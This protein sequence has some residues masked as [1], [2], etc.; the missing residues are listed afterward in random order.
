MFLA[1]KASFFC[2]S[3]EQKC[4]SVTFP[5][6]LCRLHWVKLHRQTGCRPLAANNSRK[7]DKTAKCAGYWRR[8]VRNQLQLRSRK[9]CPAQAQV[10][11]EGRPVGQS[12]S[13]CYRSRPLAHH[14]EIIPTT[15]TTTTM[16]RRLPRCP[17][18]GRAKA[19]LVAAAWHSRRPLALAP[20][21][22]MSADL[23]TATATKSRSLAEPHHLAQ[24][25]RPG[26]ASPDTA[27]KSRSLTA[28]GRAKMMGSHS[29]HWHSRLSRP[30][31]AKRGVCGSGGG[32]TTPGSEAG[33]WRQSEK[34]QGPEKG[35]WQQS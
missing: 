11:Y 1:Q 5:F 19:G 34:F 12:K 26:R 30:L 9:R 31:A 25:R 24:Q 17:A 13:R 6:P 7:H 4:A 22:N 29:C 16:C 8:N 20:Q 14:L 10:A 15:P 33:L 3:H 32:R 2:S 18:R 23:A 28:R 27:S 35:L 21:Q